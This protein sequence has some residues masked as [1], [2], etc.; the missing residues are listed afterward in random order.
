[1]LIHIAMGLTGPSC[2][3]CND[4]LFAFVRVYIPPLARII[5]GYLFLAFAVLDK[6]FREGLAFQSLGTKG[7][8][9]LSRWQRWL[10]SL[11]KDSLTN[12]ACVLCVPSNGLTFFARDF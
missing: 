11:N 8:E 5:I 10:N 2:C 12:V 9:Q 6:V 4:S 7:N 1:M 3:L